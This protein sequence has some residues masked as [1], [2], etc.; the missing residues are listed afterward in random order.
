[1]YFVIPTVW[2]GYPYNTWEARNDRTPEF[3]KDVHFDAFPIESTEAE[4]D[5]MAAAAVRG[6]LLLTMETGNSHASFRRLKAVP[7]QQPWLPHKVVIGRRLSFAGK[8]QTWKHSHR[9]NGK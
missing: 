5:C 9:F 2:R 1:M 7:E 8:S 4:E 3:V 6:A